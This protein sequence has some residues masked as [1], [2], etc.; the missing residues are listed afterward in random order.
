MIPRYE[1]ISNDDG[2][3]WYFDEESEDFM[4]EFDDC[5]L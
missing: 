2:I 1:Y 4:W 3:T 5:E